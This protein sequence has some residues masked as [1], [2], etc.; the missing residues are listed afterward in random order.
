MQQEDWIKY[1]AI[2][3]AVIGFGAILF[4]ALAH[5]G[6]DLEGR[7]WALTQLG[8]DSTSGELVQG[9]V[10]TATFEDGTVAGSSGCNNYFA[11]YAVD[12]DAIE[13]GPAGST[14]MFCESP[15]G[16]MDQEQTYL[17]LLQT[18]DSF[19]VSGDTLTLSADGTT[20]L[21]YSASDSTDGA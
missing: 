9:T 18:A 10:I 4:V 8:D 11:D 17:S 5:S 14:L 7:D 16:T 3:L 6:G 15:E 20:V 21:V 12:G 2:A 13:V 19:D 1:G